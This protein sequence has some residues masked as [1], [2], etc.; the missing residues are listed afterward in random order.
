M[1]AHELLARISDDRRQSLSSVGQC[2]GSLPQG[3][4]LWQGLATPLCAY[5]L[6]PMG[7]LY[8]ADLG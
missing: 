7:T 4:G 2:S 6:L 8:S 1:T 3:M 5:R